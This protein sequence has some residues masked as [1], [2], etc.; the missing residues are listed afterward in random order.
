MDTNWILGKIIYFENKDLGVKG[1]MRVVGKKK[2]RKKGWAANQ[3]ERG[4]GKEV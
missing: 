2:K 4:K 1:E 3:K